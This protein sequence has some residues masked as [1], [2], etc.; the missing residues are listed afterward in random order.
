MGD[1]K[2]RGVVSPQN[3]DVLSGRGALINAHPGNTQFRTYMLNFRDLYLVTPKNEKAL[4]AKMLVDKFRYLHPPGRFLKK[5]PDT[6][7]WCDIGE[8]ASLDKTRQ[9]FRGI[10]PKRNPHDSSKRIKSV[11]PTLTAMLE[12]ESRMEKLNKY[13]KNLMSGSVLNSSVNPSSKYNHDSF[14]P[15]QYASMASRFTY[16]SNLTNENDDRGLLIANNN[17]MQVPGIYYTNT[18]ISSDSIQHT[19]Q[20]ANSII[21]SAGEDIT[22]VDNYQDLVVPLVYTHYRTK[23]RMAPS[24]TKESE[25]TN[26]SFPSCSLLKDQA[27]YSQFDFE[28]FKRDPENDE[29]QPDIDISSNNVCANIDMKRLSFSFNSTIRFGDTVIQGSPVKTNICRPLERKDKES[30]TA[31][32]NDLHKKKSSTESLEVKQRPEFTNGSIDTSGTPIIYT[33]DRQSSHDRNPSSIFDDS[34]DLCDDIKCM[35]EDKDIPDANLSHPKRCS[36]PKREWFH[37]DENTCL[38]I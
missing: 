18:T 8:S 15:Y 36:L 28:N 2:L 27:Q 17:T 37:V 29:G 6:L 34:A 13:T 26:T 22:P 14:N 16:T 24:Y 3:N 9:M 32:A 10:A 11:I 35:L 7:R 38:D 21:D 31:Y 12:N 1:S 25:Y 30:V 23:N 4:F 19:S 5:D 20:D 33:I